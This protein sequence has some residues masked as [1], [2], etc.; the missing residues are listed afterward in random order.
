[1]DL[2]LVEVHTPQEMKIALRCGAKVIGINNRNLHT[3]QLDLE[4]TAKALE[5]LKEAQL[6]W[7]V[8]TISQRV[9]NVYYH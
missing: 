6:T 1:M 5:V 8:D 9:P 3:F 4:T 2:W 7:Q